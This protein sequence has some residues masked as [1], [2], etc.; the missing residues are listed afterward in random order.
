MFFLT[1]GKFSQCG[2]I[3]YLSIHWLFD[4][5]QEFGVHFFLFSFLQYLFDSA[6]SVCVFKS[7]FKASYFKSSAFVDACF[8]PITSSHHPSCFFMNSNPVSLFQQEVSQR[9]HSTFFVTPLAL[10][11]LLPLN[12]V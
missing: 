2:D 1:A 12:S 6:I 3:Y 10:Q 5:L 11:P 8:L 4:F 7:F 9:L